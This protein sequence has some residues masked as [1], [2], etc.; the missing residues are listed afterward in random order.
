MWKRKAQ[1]LTAICMVLG[2]LLTFGAPAPARAEGSPAAAAWLQ[3]IQNGAAWLA[4]TQRPDGSWGGAPDLLALAFTARALQEYGEPNAALADALRLHPGTDAKSLALRLYGT[5]DLALAAQLL[6]ASEP[7]G[8]WGETSTTALALLGLQSAGQAL[9]AGATAAL[10]ARQNPDGGWGS[11]ASYAKETAWATL[12]LARAGG[13]TDAVSRGAH[14]LATRQGRK[15]DWVY[16]T[17]TAI[18]ALALAE[19]GSQADAIAKAYG[20]L[21]TAANAGGGWG[22]APGQPGDQYATAAALLALRGAPSST[23]QADGLAYLRTLA[24]G[25]GNGSGPL[26]HL[27]T[28]TALRALTSTGTL[29]AR[30]LA[31]AWLQAQGRP[32]LEYVARLVE[33]LAL[34]GQQPDAL[35]AELTAY[36]NA[37]GGFAL[38]QGFQSNVLD[39][40][41]ALRALQT[42]GFADRN[43]LSAAY[44]FLLGQQNADGGWN[45]KQGMDS[46][47]WLTAE[48]IL[49]FRQDTLAGSEASV[50]GARTWLESHQN[51]D[52]GWGDNGSTVDETALAYGALSRLPHDPAIATRGLS[53]LLGA[54]QADGSWATNALSTA[55]AILALQEAAPNVVVQ[56]TDMTLSNWTPVNGNTVTVTAIVHNWGGSDA[57]G[58]AVDFYAGDPAAGG[59][60]IGRETVALLSPGT[61]AQVSVDWNTRGMVGPRS[62]Y[63]VADADA[64][65]YESNETDNAASLDVYVQEASPLVIGNPRPA[66]GSVTNDQTP[67][68][69]AA[70]YSSAGTDTA[71]VRMWVDEADVTAT[72]EVRVDGVS[73]TPGTA[74]LD[75]SHR[76]R[77]QA[78]DNAG[79][80]T[81]YQW[82]FIVNRNSGGYVRITTGTIELAVDVYGCFTEGNHQGVRLLYGHPYPWSSYLAVQV[83]SQIYSNGPLANY[84]LDYYLTRLTTP[85]D[86]DGDGSLD[87]AVTEWTLPGGIAVTQ[88]LTPVPYAVRYKVDVRNNGAA[89][90]DVRVRYLFD[91]QLNY[92]DGAPF[93]LPGEDLRLTT[94]REYAPPTFRVWKDYDNYDN[95]T[96][97]G[98]GWF[99]ADAIPDK[100]Q[101]AHWNYSYYSGVFDYVVNPARYVTSDSAVLFYW[102]LG[103]L[104]PGQADTV[105]TY[106]GLNNANEIRSP[107]LTVDSTAIAFASDPQ[108]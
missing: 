108:V 88:T 7:D 82:S 6:A 18:A 30:D 27:A 1:R 53:Y 83:G 105:I 70:F 60:L 20:Y 102:N 5:G 74:L 14:W 21:D 71:S 73:Y 78:A 76:V 41:L 79:Q 37:D 12:A 33:S 15:G 80:V 56:A 95:P 49:A 77:V 26:A 9:P 86:T 93:Y 68:I 11:P 66:P 25:V 36:Q 43:A 96:I 42:A 39:T 40:V 107:D 10:A 24:A 87:S 32:N 67:V 47:V 19:A 100:I 61:S 72:A 50:T 85:E 104:Q 34:S 81:E 8:T 103:V 28:A 58:V 17:D 91:T 62:L 38:Q 54:Q 35:I 97:V 55:L 92:N 90:P 45:L 99:H 101:F 48:V 57:A 31:L 75:G 64:A 23:A 94:E 46:S 84:N 89:A 3:A 29:A 65:V 4:Q 69:S 16:V 2:I 106:Y 59:V 13:F 44:R 51:A 63:V 22:L 98:E 52:G